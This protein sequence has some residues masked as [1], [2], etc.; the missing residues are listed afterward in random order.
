M[1]SDVRR[2]Q[3]GAIISAIITRNVILAETG[4]QEVIPALIRSFRWLA[5]IMLPARPSVALAQEVA[6]RAGDHA[7]STTEFV[8]LH[9][10][11][12]PSYRIMPLRKKMD[13]AG[14]RVA[15]PEVSWSTN[16]ECDRAYQQTLDEIAE[17]VI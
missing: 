7:P 3:L 17:A 11:L 5:V 1:E 2:G 4:R 9:G 12:E 16:R 8:L 15:M 10:V 14:F 6:C 13:A